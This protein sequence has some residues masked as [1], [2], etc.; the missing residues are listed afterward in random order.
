MLIKMSISGLQQL[1]EY[2]YSLPD[3][4]IM[5]ATQVEEMLAN[6]WDDPSGDTRGG[7]ACDKLRGRMESVE[8]NRPLLT[9]KIERH[10]GTVLGSVYAELQW[11]TID[12][13][14]ETATLGVGSRRVVGQKQ[15]LLKVGP[16]AKELAELIFHGKQDPRL[17]WKDGNEVRVL[18]GRVIPDGSP[19]QTVAGRRKRFWRALDAEV[20]LHGW[21]RCHSIVQKEG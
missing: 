8:W 20:L 6:C 13:D 18:I 21:K 16:I 12:V 14:R 9:F 10:G 4:P 19:K 17:H 2:L 11:W 3:G 15:P 1:R 5:D 7:M